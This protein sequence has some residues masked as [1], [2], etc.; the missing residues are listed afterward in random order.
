MRCARCEFEN[1]PG[2][3]RC[4]RCGSVLETGSVAIPVHPP[5]MPAW[6][7][8][9]RGTL[10]WLREH[11][12]M[13]ER[14]PGSSLGRALRK[15]LSSS[16]PF[17]QTLSASMLG[18]LMN[19]VPGLPHYV[20]GRFKEVRPYVALW[21]LCLVL[22]L[23]LYGSMFGSLLIGLAIG[24]HAWI[25]LQY[26]IFRKILDLAARAGVALV[27]VAVLTALYWAMPYAVAPGFTAGHTTLTV[28]AMNIRSGDYLLAN[29]LADDADRKLPRGTLVLFRPYG[30]RRVHQNL[31]ANPNDTVIG[32][33]VGLPG[34]VI[35]LRDK[36]YVADGQRLDPG[37]FPVPVWLQQRPVRFEI[38]IPRGSY[39]I[40]T[41]YTIYNNANLTDGVI[42]QACVLS[43]SD[44]RGRAFMRWWPLT[45]RGF[46]E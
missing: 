18:L 22:G 27:V 2:Q 20:K 13:P 6:Q 33:I 10:R 28:P 36:A 32:Q 40:S 16:R 31:L 37:G 44:I 34:E 12:M 19:V 39:F 8:P 15:I 29:R 9:W 41:E 11:R 1:I 21:L 45:R 46:I 42:R 23:F 35:Q 26:D 7:K 25:A 3:A 38:S 43:A 30:V 5:R 17:G 24:L 14:L 4:I